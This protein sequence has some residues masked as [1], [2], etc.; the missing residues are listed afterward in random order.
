MTE[1][2][3]F[4]L[5]VLA[6]STIVFVALLAPFIDFTAKIMIGGGDEAYIYLDRLCPSNSLE[7]TLLQDA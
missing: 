3:D 2:S 1:I 6:V 7:L 5:I 4:G